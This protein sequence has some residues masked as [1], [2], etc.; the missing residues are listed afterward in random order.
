MTLFSGTGMSFKE[1]LNNVS[2]DE[3]T[4][5]FTLFAY[6]LTPDTEE[7]GHAQMIR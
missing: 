5:G 6:D 3:Y 2:R 4:S 1:D 7:S